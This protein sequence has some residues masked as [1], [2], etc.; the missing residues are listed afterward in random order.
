[1]KKTPLHNTRPYRVF[2]GALE[3]RGSYWNP[4]VVPGRV[5]DL[6][7]DTGRAAALDG[8]ADRG[9]VLRAEKYLPLRHPGWTAGAVCAAVLCWFLAGPLSWIAGLG[10]VPLMLLI[11][12]HLLLCR[13]IGTRVPG[14]RRA[15]AAALAEKTMAVVFVNDPSW[16]DLRR[17]DKALES[18]QARD[19][20]RHDAAALAAVKAVLARDRPAPVE[21]PAPDPADFDPVQSMFDSIVTTMT[22]KTPA[23]LIAELE[24]MAARR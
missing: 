23:Q 21:E 8:G 9:R 14:I 11:L 24:D 6:G 15:R 22:A 20:T 1:M 16:M 13:Y 19:G 10:T 5:V 7:L 17:I 12:A 18:L 3:I 4:Q 2:V